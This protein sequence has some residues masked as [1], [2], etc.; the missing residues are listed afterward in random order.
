MIG[1]LLHV[2]LR[3]YAEAEA[4]A[5]APFLVGP[6]LLDLGAGEGYVA[7]A[8]RERTRLWFCSVDVGAFRR[9]AG[10]YVTYDGTRLP[11]PDAA[12]D[13]TL[14]LLTLHHC[15]EP[16]AVL[17]EVLRV[18]RR[19]LIV[20][21]SV[22]RN[23]LERFWLDLL[24]GWLNRYRHDGKMT[25][26]LAFRGPQEWQRLFV[27]RGLR[28]VEIRWLGSWGERLVHHPLLFVLEKTDLSP[29]RA[30][31]ERGSGRG[32]GRFGRN[33]EVAAAPGADG[34]REQLTGYLGSE[35]KH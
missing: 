14:L 24:D 34:T 4:K 9:A 13:T 1:R 11:F 12:F 25:V 23:R 31:L 15:V 22:Y 19:R 3:L 17:D 2:F 20:M 16:E 8:L 29:R 27:S 33:R 5:V 7:G 35:K 6:K 18:T 32:T 21:E 26:P 10:P 30:Y 28:V